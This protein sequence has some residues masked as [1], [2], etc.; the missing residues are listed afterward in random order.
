MCINIDAWSSFKRFRQ[1]WQTN[2]NRGDELLSS[3]LFKSKLQ[4]INF[5]N[6]VSI[7]NGREKRRKFKNCVLSLV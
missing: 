4:S 6:N 3:D 7:H 1:F 2:S 5:P